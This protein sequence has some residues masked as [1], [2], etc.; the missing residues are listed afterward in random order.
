MLKNKTKYIF[1]VGGVISGVGKGITSS[2]LG[3]ILKN[4][5]LKVTSIKIDPYINVDAG[6]MNPTEHGE[7][8]VL[9]D[10][11]ETDQDMGNYERFLDINLTRINYMT[12]GRVY[13]T[14]IEKERNLEYKGKCVEVVPHIPLEVIGRIKEAGEKVNADIVIIEIGG[15]IG[16]YQNMLFLE[17]ARMMKLSSPKDVLFVMVSFLPTPQK[18]GEMKTKPTQHA[19]RTLNGSGIQPDILIARADLP[20]DK[21]RKEKLSLFCNISADRVISAPDV[22]SIYDIPLNFE[23]EKLSDKLCEIL[24]LST[25]KIDT[26]AWGKWK[27]FA[28]RSHNGK[29]T[30]KIAM[31]GKYFETGDFILSDSYLSVI[32][33]IKYSSYMQDRKPIMTWLNSS[34][35]E[36]NPTKL[37]ELKKYDG[38]IIPGGFGS[39]GVEGNLNVVKFVR[40]NKIPYFGLCYGMQ[41]IVIEYARN[42]LGLKDAN[43]KEIN[44]NAKS[45]VIDIMESQKEILKNNSYGGSMR[46]GEYKAILRD[47]TI[48]KE[49]YKTKEIL[50]RHRHRYEVNPAFVGDLEA[51]GLVFSGRSPDGHLMEIAELPK[52]KHPFF[53]GTQYHPEFLAHPL[54][55]HPLFSA[56]I[57][58]CIN[59][60]K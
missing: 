59:N 22:D 5:G 33:A 56:F 4:R 18:V 2:S 37:K 3:L 49:A 19:V 35:F 51:K 32:E 6:T 15:T 46:L 25:K 48:A 38:V 45:M 10:G 28:K 12:T 26:K 53:L 14:V 1:V 29:E 7:V 31:I 50:E 52:S 47:G 27:N 60:K 40:E 41:M 24:D 9:K 23:K 34:D 17:A 11:D 13:K 42:V 57:K 39:R 44:S 55:P 58:A 36:K 21:K 20:L 30:V 16:E 8:F 43:T 54:T